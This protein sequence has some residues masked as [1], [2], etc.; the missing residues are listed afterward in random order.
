MG[1]TYYNGI[2]FTCFVERG[3]QTVARIPD[4]LRFLWEHGLELPADFEHPSPWPSPPASSW[5]ALL[6]Q[7]LKVGVRPWYHVAPPDLSDSNGHIIC[8][9]KEALA[10]CS[11]E[12]VSFS[13]FDKTLHMSLSIDVYPLPQQSIHLSPEGL[14][15][16]P[17]PD[18]IDFPLPAY[19]YG[20]IT[21]GTSYQVYW[22][23]E[24]PSL[25][26]AQPSPQIWLHYQ[27]VWLAF[28]EWVRLLCSW[29]QP[30][31]GYG[32]NHLY[33]Q[34]V[35]LEDTA[36]GIQFSLTSGIYDFRT[37]ADFGVSQALQHGA[38][39]QLSPLLRSGGCEYLPPSLLDDS[40][41]LS[42]LQTPGLL[43]ERLPNGGL[44]KLPRLFPYQYPI[45]IAL[46]HFQAA[47]RERFQ[48]GGQRDLALRYG[49]RAIQI[50][51]RLYCD[52]RQLPYPLPPTEEAPIFPD[53]PPAETELIRAA[54][55][56]RRQLDELLGPTFQ[57]RMQLA[58]QEAQEH[59]FEKL[60]SPDP[61]DR[62]DALARLSIHFEPP[63][64]L[65]EP[66][67]QALL[68]DP[69]RDCRAA[70]ATLLLSLLERNSHDRRFLSLCA[71]VAA[72]PHEDPTIRIRAYQIMRSLVHFD[73]YELVELERL[74]GQLRLPDFDW[75]RYLDWDFVHTYAS[76]TSPTSSEQQ[77]PPPSD[78][79]QPH[80]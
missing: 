40:L 59:L 64:A 52:E 41:L 15:S 51:E 25:D 49:Q 72:N 3:P 32:T 67:L 57:E 2:L 71:R 77:P 42:W 8:P 23:F 73:P 74:L 78:Q 76:D 5:D 24:R 66:A 14:P 56:L 29:L 9:L 55:D 68:H 47:S 39:P 22:P 12:E 61:Q 46:Y 16:L 53:P 43:L 54:Y 6:D 4:L 36:F 62:Y 11:R 65:I 50:L 58:H 44:L 19:P 20:T 38:R 37:A 1:N 79:A 21:L 13:L 27:Q 48:E 30:L 17:G 45:S 28:L 80:P 7:P 26:P 60:A 69:D 35:L 34:D 18:G 10:L 31:Y 75:T 63:E 70:A 33:D